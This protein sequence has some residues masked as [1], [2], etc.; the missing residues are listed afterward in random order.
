LQSRVIKIIILYNK[1][2]IL[3]PET[4]LNDFRKQ[5]QNNMVDH[6]EKYSAK[7]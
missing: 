7:S 6:D 5:E 4:K 2:N 3:P 1:K